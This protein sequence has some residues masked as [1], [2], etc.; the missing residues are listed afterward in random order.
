MAST[1]R[2]TFTIRMFGAVPARGWN[3]FLW[4]GAAGRVPSFPWSLRHIPGLLAAFWDP[5]SR[6]E[7]RSFPPWFTWLHTQLYLILTRRTAILQ[8]YN[9][10]WTHALAGAIKAEYTRVKSCRER[11]CRHDLSGCTQII[12]IRIVHR[13]VHNI[14]PRRPK[15]SLHRGYR[16]MPP[17]SRVLYICTYFCGLIANT[18][19]YQ[20]NRYYDYS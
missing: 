5:S 8:G 13:C 14:G 16:S 15:V 12:G 3:V 9:R 2:L 1:I 20:K 4:L 11:Q 10:S 17:W 7:A 18:R 19:T 6:L